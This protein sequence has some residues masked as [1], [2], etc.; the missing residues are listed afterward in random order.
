M[1]LLDPLDPLDPLD[2][3]DASLPLL[4][5]LFLFVCLCHLSCLREVCPV[6]DD[7]TAAGIGRSPEQKYGDCGNTWRELYLLLQDSTPLEELPTAT[8]CS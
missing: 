8:I 7:D 1:D 6:R 5:L 2:L 3:W 4:V